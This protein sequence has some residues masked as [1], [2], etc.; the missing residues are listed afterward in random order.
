MKFKIITLGCKVNTYESNMMREK[1]IASGF[2][3]TI[4][5]CDILIINTC[6]VTNMADAKSRKLIRYNKRENPNA[7]TLVCGCSSENHREELLDLGIDILIGN[8]EKSKVVELI[9][10]YIKDNKKYIKFYNTR[11]LEFENMHVSKF[12]NQTRA[13]IKIQDGCNNFCAYCIIPYMRGVS[14]SKDFNLCLDEARQ[15]VENGHKEIVLTGIDTGSYGKD[16][17]SSL[18]SLLK[19][20]VKIDGLERIRLS[21]I[22]IDDLD[23]DFINFYKHDKMCDHLHIS[24]QSG[25]DKILK[26][27]LRRYDCAYFLDKINKI[28]EVKPNVN[29][30]TDVI[31]GFPCEDDKDFNDTLKYCKK[32]SF[33]KIHVFPYS[34]RN[35]TKA[36]IMKNQVSGDIK[37]DRVNKLIELSNKLQYEYN[38]LYLNKIVDVLI[39]EVNGNISIGHTTNYLKVIINSKLKE[40]EIVKVKIN[41]IDIEEVYGEY[42]L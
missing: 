2:V 6:S 37:K 15:L 10:N 19:E 26:L 24:L 32:V 34:K 30:T 12:T 22:D 25:S 18:T 33:S 35:G 40:N 7:I 21:S 20:M 11:R 36:A 4:D 42:Q 27:M 14:R 16:I 3:E 38:K 28:R 31:V 13:Y 5:D 9:N 41:K 8:N 39:E 29:I 23:D 1:L 17:G